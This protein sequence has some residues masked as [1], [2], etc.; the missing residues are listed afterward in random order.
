[1][2]AVSDIGETTVGQLAN[3]LNVSGP[4]VTL[5]VNKLAKAGLLARTSKA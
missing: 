1:M 5:Q 2:A 4:F 3:D